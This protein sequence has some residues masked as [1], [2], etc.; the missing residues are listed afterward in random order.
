VHNFTGPDP[1][2]ICV[3]APDINGNSSPFDFLQA[4]K[5]NVY[6]QHYFDRDE[7]LLLAAHSKRREQKTVNQYYCRLRYIVS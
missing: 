6:C 4:N 3:V 5:A 2:I 7:L 1:G